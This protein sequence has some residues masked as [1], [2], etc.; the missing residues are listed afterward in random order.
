MFLL[1]SYVC[2]CHFWMETGNKTKRN[3]MR[4][5]YFM[6]CVFSIYKWLFIASWDLNRLR[7]FISDTLKIRAV[8]NNYINNNALQI[9]MECFE[10]RRPELYTI[11]RRKHYGGSTMRNYFLILNRMSV[12]LCFRWFHSISNEEKPKISINQLPFI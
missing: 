11:E 3:T 4:W 5:C 2:L 1:D 8:P 9:N 6:F 7:T 12:L 10:M